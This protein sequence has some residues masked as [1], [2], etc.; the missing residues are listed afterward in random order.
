MIFNL[1]KEHMEKTALW[2]ICKRMPKGSLLH[3]HLGAMVDLEW[4]IGTAIETTGICIASLGGG[5]VNEEMRGTTDVRILFQK[6]G[7][8]DGSLLWRNEYVS[9]TW[10]NLKSA[11][12][13]FPEG[14]KVG[15]V[16]FLKSKCTISQEDNVAHHLGVDDIWRKLSEAFHTI[17]PIEFY[18]PITRK[19]IRRFLQTAKEDGI[20]WVEMRGMTRTFRLEGVDEPMEGRLELVRV[21]DEEIKGFLASEEGKDFW[22]ARLIW[23]SLRSFGTEKVIEGLCCLKPRANQDLLLRRYDVVHP[24][25]EKVPSSHLRLR[26]GRSRR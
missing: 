20:K 22:G 11:S 17:A 19:F 7:L 13:S 18:E 5:L 14:G 4:V 16:R 6:N 1:A 3:C 9:G 25:K 15:F 10:V 23:D 2:S 12:E 21:M 24:S 26:S 8:A